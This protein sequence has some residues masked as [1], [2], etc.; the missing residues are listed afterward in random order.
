[1]QQGIARPPARRIAPLD[2]ANNP[3]VSAADI[4]SQIERRHS[5]QPGV[6]LFL[7]APPD[8]R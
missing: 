3:D 1:M 5:D 8:G 4:D 6:K 7:S 2:T